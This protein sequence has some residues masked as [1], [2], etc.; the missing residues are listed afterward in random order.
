MCPDA[1]LCIDPFHVVSWATKV[2]ATFE[3]RGLAIFGSAG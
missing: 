3:K 2:E 1:V